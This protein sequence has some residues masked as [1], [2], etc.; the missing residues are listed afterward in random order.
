QANY[1]DALTQLQWVITQ[2]TQPRLQQIARIS[3]AR[4]M[5]SQNNP[6]AAMETIS[7]VN[8][9]QFAPLIAW[10]KGDIYTQQDDVKNAHANYEIA[11]KAFGQ[12]PPAAKLLNQLLAQ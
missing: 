8:D 7:I 2:G 5:L 10:I 11:K 12:F 1:A 6:K 3:A 9:E 4:I